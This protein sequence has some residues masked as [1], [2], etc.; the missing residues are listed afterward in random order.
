MR[1]GFA[2]WLLVLVAAAAA[3]LCAGFYLG[4]LHTPYGVS[5]HH[6]PSAAITERTLEAEESTEETDALPESDTKP[7]AQPAAD[8]LDLNAA[9]VEEL[10][11]LPGI[12][13]VLAE[14]IVVYRTACRGYLCAEQLMEV[15]GIGE[16]KFA[17]LKD[18]VTVGEYNEDPGR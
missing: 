5:V 7:D 12:G 15:S 11:Q 8:A 2:A 18:F 14:R 16:A 1:K 9:S 13:P 6:L 3:A 4:Q 17:Q 10:Q